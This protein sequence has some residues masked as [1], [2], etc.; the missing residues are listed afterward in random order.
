MHKHKL[1]MLFIFLYSL[2]ALAEGKEDLLQVF[3]MTY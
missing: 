3:L 1:L 2:V